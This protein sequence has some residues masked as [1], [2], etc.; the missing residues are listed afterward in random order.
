MCVSPLFR[1]R[2][3][4]VSVGASR[5][6]NVFGRHG[7][8]QVIGR[9]EY[10]FVL[11]NSFSPD[12][13][14]RI[15]CGQCIDC[16]LSYAKS[17][18][19]RC[20]C[21][22]KLYPDNYCWF[23]TFTYDDL[24]LPKP[25]SILNRETGS[26][27][28]F[29]PLVKKD[30]QDFLKRLRK[31]FSGV[32]YYLCGEY[33]SK[34]FRPHYHVLLFNLPLRDLMQNDSFT[35]SRISELDHHVLYESKVLNDCWKDSDGKLKGL[36]A[37]APFSYDTACYTARYVMKKMKGTSFKDFN[38]KFL[39]FDSSSGEVIPFPREY[40][41]MSLKPGIGG[42]YFFS[43]LDYMYHFD[44]LPLFFNKEL[45]HC[46]PPRYADKLADAR[47]LLTDEL[48][49]IR[50]KVAENALWQKL[51]FSGLTEEQYYRSRFDILNSKS[52]RL[53]RTI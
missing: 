48:K 14:Q 15:P 35:R 43:H 5:F 8:R 26:I 27:T 1:L 42:D 49:E 7:S 20:V 28:P 31:R 44:D 25:I 3:E 21:E 12:Y 2:D 52:R 4:F 41:S 50:E 29:Y 19:V 6:P 23:V 46:R 51:S 53:V 16:R 30:M 22:S 39:C 24:H 9:D 32:R 37:V 34:S 10:D 40:V 33:G 38:D 17:W 13:M 47:G 18:A 11:H 36:I 45:H